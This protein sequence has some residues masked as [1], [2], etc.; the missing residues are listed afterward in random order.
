M[1][2]I[3]IALVVCACVVVLIVS[4][5]AKRSAHDLGAMSVNWIAEHRVE[6]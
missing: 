6:R 1:L 3:G 2:W 5:V 4:T